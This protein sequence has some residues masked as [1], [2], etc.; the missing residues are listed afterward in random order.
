MSLNVKTQY[1]VILM[2]C[3][4]LVRSEYTASCP[5]PEGE[6]VGVGN[7]FLASSPFFTRK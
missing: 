4:Q 3:S 6:W 1:L 7:D 2:S 5:R